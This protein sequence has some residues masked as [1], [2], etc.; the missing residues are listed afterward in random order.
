MMTFEL[1]RGRLAVRRA[2]P[3]AR[4]LSLDLETTGL[5][6]ATAEIIAI[7]TVPVCGDLVRVGQA[8]STLVRPRHRSAAAGIVAHHLRPS[9]VAAAPRLDDVLPDL[10]VRI[11]DADALLVHHAALDVRVLRRACADAG[12]PWPGPAVID[13]L[14]LIE[15]FR[16]R[17]RTLGGGAR[18][19]RD[20]AGA[21]AALGLPPH[22][23]HD[24]RADAIATAELYLALSAKLRA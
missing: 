10:L 9:D 8:T 16:R 3:G 15:R 4:L 23:A 11:A 2:S 22:T 19:P 7:G 17:Q 24:A 21:R 20:L 5:D 6:A 1:A 18:L 12:W 14:D 13:T